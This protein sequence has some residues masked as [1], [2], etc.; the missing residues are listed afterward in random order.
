MTIKLD[1]YG[2]DGVMLYMGF[3]MS[4]L[5]KKSYKVMGKQQLVWFPIQ[6]Q[7]ENQYKISPIG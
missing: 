4:I 5:P 2:M 7:L 6:L 1:G 3:D